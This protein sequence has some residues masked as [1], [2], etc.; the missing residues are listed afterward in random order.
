MDEGQTMRFSKGEME[1]IRNTFSGKGEEILYQIRDVLLQFSDKVPMVSKETLDIL[2]KILVPDLE[3]DVPLGQQADLYLS[4][5]NIKEIHPEVAILHIK[6]KDLVVEYLKQRFEVLNGQKLHYVEEIKLTDLK[7]K[8]NKTDT[9]RF[10]SMMAYT[11]LVNAFIDGSLLHLKTM[12]NKKE[13]TPEEL[14]KKAQVNSS[15]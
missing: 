15:K 9:E 4:L 5:T 14:E 1:L 2:E 12:A 13:E 6:A 11:F 3:V 10:V 7:S 8:E